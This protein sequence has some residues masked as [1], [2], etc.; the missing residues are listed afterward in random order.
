[1]L[2]FRPSAIS[3]VFANPSEMSRKLS[4]I[5]AVG[6]QQFQPVGQANACDVPSTPDI[7][8]ITAEAIM[9][10]AMTPYADRCFFTL[11]I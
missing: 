11:F 5:P 3:N 2:A 4:V 1:M 7:S 9:A 8:K 6:C 10:I